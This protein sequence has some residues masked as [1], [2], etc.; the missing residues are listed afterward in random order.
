MD[1]GKF[2]ASKVIMVVRNPLDVFPS[3]ASMVNEVNHAA[4]PGF[5]YEKDYPEWWDWFVKK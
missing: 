2:T 1:A 4:K 5:E 3:Y